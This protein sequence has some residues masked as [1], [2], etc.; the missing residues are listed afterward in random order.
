VAGAVVSCVEQPI[1]QTAIKHKQVSKR[2]ACLRFVAAK[3][4]ILFRLE[5]RAR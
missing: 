4:F 1:A 2:S 5:V 3:D